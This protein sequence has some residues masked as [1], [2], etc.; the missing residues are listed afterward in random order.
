MDIKSIQN[1]DHSIKSPGEIKIIPE[2][3]LKKIAI[4]NYNLHRVI[5]TNIKLD[6]DNKGKNFDK[7]A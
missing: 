1:S 7:Y 6:E 4:K 2:K 3:H 5:V